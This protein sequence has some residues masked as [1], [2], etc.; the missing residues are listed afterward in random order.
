MKIESIIGKLE[1]FIASAA[2]AALYIWL[3]PSP[4]L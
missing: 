2:Q 3:R 1:I 4:V